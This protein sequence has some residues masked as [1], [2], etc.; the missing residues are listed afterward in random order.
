MKEAF[1]FL[2]QYSDGS[3]YQGRVYAFTLQEALETLVREMP[4]D[5]GASKAI[6]VNVEMKL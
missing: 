4:R 3:I 6:K 2:M 5:E 1:N